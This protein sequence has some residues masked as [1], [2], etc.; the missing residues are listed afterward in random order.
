ME[1]SFSRHG[2]ELVLRLIIEQ[3]QGFLSFGYEDLMI[4]QHI[5]K[6]VMLMCNEEYLFGKNYCMVKS[7]T[8][9]YLGMIALSSSLIIQSQMD[10]LHVYHAL[11]YLTLSQPTLPKGGTTFKYQH[12]SA[13]CQ[14]T[15]Y[16]VKQNW[17]AH[18]P[19][20]QMYRVAQKF[21]NIKL[22]LK[23]WSKCTCENFK[24]KLERNGEK[25]LQVEQSFY[26]NLIVST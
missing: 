25:L 3:A 14:D 15:H 5:V 4:S 8:E 26:F 9:L 10:L 17:K 16:V 1:L 20:T 2:V 12:S 24:H 6:D 19:S 7:Q 22:D 18:I 21:N 11:G 13:Q 23:T